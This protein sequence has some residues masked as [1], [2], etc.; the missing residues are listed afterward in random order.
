MVN[1]KVGIVISLLLCLG[2]YACTP[3]QGSA[4]EPVKAGAKAKVSEV[5]PDAPGDAPKLEFPARVAAGDR[6]PIVVY[7]AQTSESVQL[8][9]GDSLIGKALPWSNRLGGAYTY[10]VILRKKGDRVVKVLVG[11]KVAATAP[12]NVH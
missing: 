8:K 1:R 6:F 9:V 12:I 11:K 7:M 5:V 4:E 10:S 3:A 2:N